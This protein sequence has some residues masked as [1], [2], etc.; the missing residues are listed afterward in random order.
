MLKCR[1]TNLDPGSRPTFVLSDI[2]NTT[3]NFTFGTVQDSS[4]GGLGCV[5]V[6]FSSTLG[7]GSNIEIEIFIFEQFGTI[8]VGPE[9]FSVT[10]KTMTGCL[11]VKC[12]HPNM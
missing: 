3:Q 12:G 2:D 10:N 6:P 1:P 4:Y 11:L 5:K 7:A 9:T 8:T